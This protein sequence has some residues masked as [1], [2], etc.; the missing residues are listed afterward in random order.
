[1]MNKWLK[2]I[3]CIGFALMFCFLSIGYASLNDELYISGSVSYDVPDASESDPNLN[4]TEGTAPPVVGESEYT[5]GDYIYKYEGNGDGSKEDYVGWH[6]YLSQQGKDKLKKGGGGKLD[7]IMETIDGEPITSLYETFKDQEYLVEAPRIPNGV[8][9]LRSAFEGCTSL[10]TYAGSTAHPGDF[11]DYYIPLS[12][13]NMSNTFEDCTGMI[14]APEIPLYVNDPSSIFHDCTSL[15]GVVVM[16][17]T[18]AS[19]SGEDTNNT[20]NSVDFSKQKV[21]LVGMSPVM[22]KIGDTGKNYCANCNGYCFE[23]INIAQDTGLSIKQGYFTYHYSNSKHDLNLMMTCSSGAMPESFIIK[24]GDSDNYTVYTASEGA[25]S[26]PEGLRY[27]SESG[28]LCISYTLLGEYLDEALMPKDLSEIVISASEASAASYSLN[29]ANVQ[30]LSI[31]STEAA[32]FDLD[33]KPNLLLTLTPDEGYLLPKSFI[34]IIGETTYTIYTTAEED[35]AE[36]EMSVKDN[37]PGMGYDTIENKLFISDALL[38]IDGSA[39]VITATAVLPEEEPEPT[40][41]NT[42]TESLTE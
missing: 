18:Y 19:T 9:T 3:L 27:D 17:A 31:E 25:E 38:P 29:T 20:F 15:T 41:E 4:P 16:N 34:V 5:Y 39:V 35:V 36:G 26:N 30:N 1:M 8:V 13:Q 42:P 12:V 37:P 21:T 10:V 11:S 24:L 23:K 7:P 14:S 40:D 32:T 2:S 6:V 22:D 28:T 33:S